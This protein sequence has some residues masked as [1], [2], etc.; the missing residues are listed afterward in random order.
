[1]DGAG[2]RS[3]LNVKQL[4][5]NYES[6]MTIK[7]KI[8]RVK[9]LFTEYLDQKELRK[10]PVRFS[11]LEEIYQQEGHFDADALYVSM[12]NRNFK[13][14][15]A[16]IYNTLEVLL[17]CQLIK[18]RQFGENLGLYEK[19]YGFKQHDHLICADCNRIMEFCDPRVHIIQQMIESFY[20]FKITD[21][22]LNFYGNCMNKDCQEK[23]NVH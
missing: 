10:T 3:I 17:D 15:R 22:S 4:H 19:S 13:V 8:N 23:S 11:I 7:D 1:M 18:R 21:H 6:Y 5:G 20:N 12:R 9:Q 2:C 14:S 16:T